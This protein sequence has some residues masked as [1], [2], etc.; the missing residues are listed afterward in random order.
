M[1][2]YEDDPDS[3]AR[4]EHIC[5]PR[6]F[7]TGQAY[8]YL[9]LPFRRDRFASSTFMADVAGASLLAGSGLPEVF[10]LRHCAY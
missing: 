3:S 10:A 5:T 7:S 2:A 8:P 6:Q 4:G 1:E 9:L